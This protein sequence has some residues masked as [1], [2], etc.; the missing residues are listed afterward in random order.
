[1]REGIDHVG[2]TTVRDMGAVMK[3][4]TGKAGTSADGRKV[5]QL[6]KAALSG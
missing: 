4:V 2:A 5:S 1:M 3:Y 6:V